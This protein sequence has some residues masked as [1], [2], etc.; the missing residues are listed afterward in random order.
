MSNS[1]DQ[2]QAGHVIRPDLGPNACRGCQQT[3]KVA[4][5]GERV[6]QWNQTF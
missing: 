6:V 2:D 4:T 1:L 5:S 3:T